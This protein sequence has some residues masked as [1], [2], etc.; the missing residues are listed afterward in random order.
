[1]HLGRNISY[2]CLV[3]QSVLHQ[4][5]MKLVMVYLKENNREIKFHLKKGTE[6]V[7]LLQGLIEIVVKLRAENFFYAFISCTKHSFEGHKILW[8]ERIVWQYSI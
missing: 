1:M 5:K 8:I 2:E 7:V 4:V 6:K 3:N